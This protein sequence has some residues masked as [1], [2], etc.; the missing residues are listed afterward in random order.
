MAVSSEITMNW[1]K[2]FIYKYSTS[3]LVRTSSQYILNITKYKNSPNKNC[4][5]LKTLIIS[6]SWHALRSF[7]NWKYRVPF[8][9]MSGRDIWWNLLRRH[10]LTQQRNPPYD[11]WPKNELLTCTLEINSIVWTNQ[12]CVKYD[13]KCVLKIISRSSGLDIM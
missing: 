9:C 8:L 5:I 11:F 13:E 3:F 12:K 2:N 6:Y 7:N 10:L 4:S 1:I